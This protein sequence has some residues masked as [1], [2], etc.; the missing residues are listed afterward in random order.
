MGESPGACARGALMPA[1]GLASRRRVVGD[2]NGAERWTVGRRFGHAGG[3]GWRRRVRRIVGGLLILRRMAAA[4]GLWSFALVRRGAGDVGRECGGA[5]RWRLERRAAELVRRQRRGC[6]SLR[7]ERR[8]G[9]SCG[10][11]ARI[12]AAH[13]IAKA[14]EDAAD[15]HNAEEDAEQR[16]DAQGQVGVRPGF[17]AIVFVEKRVHG[18]SS[19]AAGGGGAGTMPGP[20]TLPVTVLLNNEISSMGRGKTMVVFFSVPISVRVCR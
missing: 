18:C 14:E 19:V 16:A 17:F 15:E 5:V 3:L 7:G 8:N 4:G 1:C 12:A 13:G 6:G 20:V 9:N 2:R 11:G 10:S